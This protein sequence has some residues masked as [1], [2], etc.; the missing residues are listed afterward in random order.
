MPLASYV[1]SAGPVRS[2]LLTANKHFMLALLSMTLVA[3]LL[4]GGLGMLLL[5]VGAYFWHLAPYRRGV[6]SDMSEAHHSLLLV[7]ED[8]EQTLP[9][10][11]KPREY[12][13]QLL[14]CVALMI[15]GLVR[16][17]SP[18]VLGSVIFG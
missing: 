14:C 10:P 3:F 11:R 17:E 18:G 16:F 12:F 7:H 15:L 6:H 1:A 13:S 8:A 5:A 4:F 9:G 2:P